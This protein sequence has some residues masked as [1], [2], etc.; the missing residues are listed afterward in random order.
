MLEKIPEWFWWV[1]A[2]FAAGVIGQFGKSLTL[3]FLSLFSS[4]SG[5]SKDATEVGEASPI[6]NEAISAKEQKKIS[7][8][9]SKR[10]KKEAKMRAKAG[11]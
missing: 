1:A 5:E 2:I 11:D 9:E 3:K 8:A 7:K 6:P 10:A 4:N